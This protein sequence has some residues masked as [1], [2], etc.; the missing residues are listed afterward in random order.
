V[1]PDYAL[2]GTSQGKMQLIRGAESRAEVQNGTMLTA[3]GST[4]PKRD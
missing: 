2:K 1:A 3:I 4:A